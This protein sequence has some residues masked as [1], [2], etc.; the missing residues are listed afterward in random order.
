MGVERQNILEQIEKNIPTECPDCF[1]R[2]YFKGSGKYTCPRCHK[3]YYDYF[4]L[5]KKYL[6]GNGPAPAVDIATNTGISLEIIDT[7]L[8]DGSLEMPKEFKDVK[9]CERCGAF[10]PVGRYCQK[11]IESTSMGIMDIFKDEEAQRKKFAKSRFDRENETKRQ[12][13][14]DKM[15]YLNHIRDDRK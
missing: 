15:H 1:E 2:L 10:F 14:K 8:E 5:I 4:G 9:R 6:E 7:L 11:C 3:I 12:Y 13:E